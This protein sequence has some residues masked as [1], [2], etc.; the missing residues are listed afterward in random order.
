MR[1]VPVKNKNKEKS[2]DMNIE[3]SKNSNE[4]CTFLLSGQIGPFWAVL[5]FLHLK[6]KYA[7]V[8]GGF[9]MFSWTIYF[10]INEVL[11]FVASA[12]KSC[13]Q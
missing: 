6:L 12:Q 7:T 9:F 11:C 8:D 3:C 1:Q 10:F 2:R 5:K 13:L 4:P